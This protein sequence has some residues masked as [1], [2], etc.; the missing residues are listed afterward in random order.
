MTRVFIIAAVAAIGLA[1]CARMQDMM[2]KTPGASAL[3]LPTKDSTVRGSVKFAQKDD[4]VIVSGRI[5]GL[6]PGPHGFH[7]H[8][9]GNC[10]APDGSSA[11]PHFNPGTTKH[12][13][14][15][16]NVRHGGD[17]GNIVADA[18]GVS[19]FTIE[20]AGISLGAEPTSVIGRSI[21]VHAKPDDLKTD[22]SGGS[23]A[24]LACGLIGKDE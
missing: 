2:T 7:I 11:G 8:E 20:V 16:G 4:H 1:G 23:G 22:P 14:P 19:E 18:N 10:T 12:G 6:T 17:L 5:T 24:R 13:G 15:A 3:V 9:K 21:I